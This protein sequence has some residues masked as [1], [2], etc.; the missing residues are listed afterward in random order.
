[1]K[2]TYAQESRVGKSPRFFDATAMRNKS[3]TQISAHQFISV[4]KLYTN[5]FR[6]SNFDRFKNLLG[7]YNTI[8]S[9]Q[10]SQTLFV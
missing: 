1:M 10:S 7:T 5:Q 4:A 6:H 8:I 9:N 2:C 3:I